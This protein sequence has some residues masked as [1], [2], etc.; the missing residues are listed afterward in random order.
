MTIQQLIK[1]LQ[2]IENKDREV[3]IVIGNEDD[4]TMVFD[5]FELHN[6]HDSETSIEV[7][8]NDN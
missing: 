3:S 1:Q 6:L 2:E 4:N 8:C 7:F 5:Y